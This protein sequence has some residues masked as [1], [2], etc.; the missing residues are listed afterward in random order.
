MFLINRQSVY[1][2]C[3]GKTSPMSVAQHG[4]AGHVYLGHHHHTRRREATMACMMSCH[5]CTVPLLVLLLPA[6]PHIHTPTVGGTLLFS[7][8]SLPPSS[9]SPVQAVSLARCAS[10]GE[11]REIIIAR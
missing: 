3:D 10:E 9:I 6:V 5:L 1:S 11:E 2:L 4:R 7:F 8:L